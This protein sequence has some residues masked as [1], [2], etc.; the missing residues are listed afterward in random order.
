MHLV[1]SALFM[2]SY[3]AYLSP[4]SFALFA[5]AYMTTSL[6]W[7]VARGRPA[8]PLAAFYAE[9]SARPAEPGA[10]HG[11]A[12]APGALDA[13]DPS[14]N[15]WLPIVQSTLQHKDDHIHKFQ[16]SLLHFA[17]MLSATPPGTFRRE[18]LEGAEV[19]DGTLFIRVA[20]L[21]AGRLGWMREGQEDKGWDRIGLF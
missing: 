7:F 6:A 2:P 9:V 21:T 16:R 5:R 11:V 3:A 12:P 13:R 17:R 4:T 10:P 19:L 20:G 14:P 15:G 8:L 1:T 18:G